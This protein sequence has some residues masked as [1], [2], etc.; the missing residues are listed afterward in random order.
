MIRCCITVG[1]GDKTLAIEKLL[2]FIN[3]AAAVAAAEGDKVLT[4]GDGLSSEAD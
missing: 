4:E 2:S 1:V 3:P